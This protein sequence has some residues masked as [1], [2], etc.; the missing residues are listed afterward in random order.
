[1]SK[2]RQPKLLAYLG[3]IAIKFPQVTPSVFLLVLLGVILFNGILIERYRY[4]RLA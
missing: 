3:A 4:S 2:L 1:M